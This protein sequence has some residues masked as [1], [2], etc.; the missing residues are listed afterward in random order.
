MPT[1]NQQLYQP[2]P[3]T[4]QQSFPSHFMSNPQPSQHSQFYHI[5]QQFHQSQAYNVQSQ[6]PHHYNNFN[7]IPP[8][9]PPAFT[10]QPKYEITGKRSV[11]K[12]T[13]RIHELS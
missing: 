6:S 11:E 10:Q 5:G 9:Q 4:H 3:Q 1:H 7:P 2:I 8:P 13:A 12:L